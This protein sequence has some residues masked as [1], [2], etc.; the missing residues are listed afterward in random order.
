MSATRTAQAYPETQNLAAA[1]GV[2]ILAIA[3]MFVLAF[4]VLSAPKATVSSPASGAAPALSDHGSISDPANVSGVSA[5]AISDHG[6][7]SDPANV[8]VTSSK[9]FTRGNHLSMPR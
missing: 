5:P 1:L 4:G 6:S 7:I 2:V 3:V 8:V 9:S